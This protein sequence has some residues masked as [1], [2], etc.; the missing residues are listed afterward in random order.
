VASERPAFN[1]DDGA[2]NVPGVRTL[3]DGYRAEALAVED[4]LHET[5]DRAGD[6]DERC[7]LQTHEPGELSRHL[8]VEVVEAVIDLLE[9]PVNAVL[10]R[11]HPEIQSDRALMQCLDHAAVL[12]DRAFEECY[13]PVDS[14]HTRTFTI[15]SST[16]CGQQESAQR[17]KR[18][19]GNPRRAAVARAKVADFAISG[20]RRAASPVYVRNI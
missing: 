11:L 9:A 18:A 19:I 17:M 5:E 15:A 8:R 6:R 3:E 4:G 2:S 1:Q 20:N 12:L 13:S 14:F 16:P 7:D 10:E